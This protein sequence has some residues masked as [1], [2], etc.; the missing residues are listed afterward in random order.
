MK[1]SGSPTQKQVAENL[2][3]YGVFIFQSHIGL[4]KLSFIISLYINS[5]TVLVKIPQQIKKL[6]Q[7]SEIKF[8]FCD[9]SGSKMSH[10]RLENFTCSNST[11]DKQLQQHLSCN[12]ELTNSNSKI[13]APCPECLV[14]R[15]ILGLMFFFSVIQNK[16]E[17]HQFTDNTDFQYI[18]N[19]RPL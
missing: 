1:Q 10:Y 8:N 7:N 13:C 9:I 5:Y 16:M 11:Y 18:P 14:T 15:T 17:R 19:Q 6:K 4:S 3:K 12:L 2:T